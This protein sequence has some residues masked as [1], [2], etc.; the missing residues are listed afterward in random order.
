MSKYPFHPLWEVSAPRQAQAGLDGEGM[1]GTRT[2]RSQPRTLRSFREVRALLQAK[3]QVGTASAIE[4]TYTHSRDI[5]TQPFAIIP[6]LR[7]Q[8]NVPSEAAPHAAGLCPSE[9]LL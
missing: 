2:A 3:P 5:Q 4:K 1:Q 9:T 8:S 7:K 6:E